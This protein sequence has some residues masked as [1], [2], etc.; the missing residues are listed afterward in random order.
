MVFTRVEVFTN[1]LAYLDRIREKT[2]EIT[3]T[4]VATRHML[5]LLCIPAR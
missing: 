2:T 5:P 4:F 3:S 1:L